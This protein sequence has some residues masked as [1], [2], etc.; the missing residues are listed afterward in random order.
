MKPPVFAGRPKEL[1]TDLFGRYASVLSDWVR[2]ADLVHLMG[3]LGV[4][5]QAVR[6]TVARM[7]RRGLLTSEVRAGQRGYALTAV[8]LERIAQV[9]RRIFPSG[10][11]P[12]L[13]DGWV[14]VSFSIPETERDRRHLL[15]RR[16]TWLGL[17]NLD[18]G[19]WLGPARL[20]DEVVDSIRALELDHTC[21]VFTAHYDAFD[22]MGVVAREVWDLAAAE[23]GY[24]RFLADHRSTLARARRRTVSDEAA[25]VDYTLALHQWRELPFDDPD[26]PAELMPRH[27]PGPPAL[28]L[29]NELRHRLEPG[30]FRFVESVTRR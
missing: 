13:A 25:Y 14:L 3:L 11:P 19:L 5:E 15:R 20:R 2:I 10:D 6:S 8:A 23:Q 18:G 22:D 17:G 21:H 4:D 7:A 1:M 24:R 16:L 29:F 27:W 30:A 28:K 9:D 26:L 12:A